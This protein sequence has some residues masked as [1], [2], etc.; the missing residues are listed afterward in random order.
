MTTGDRSSFL[1]GLDYIL[2]FLLNCLRP[3]QVGSSIQLNWLICARWINS[4]RKGTELGIGDGDKD[5]GMG[6]YLLEQNLSG[7]YI[8]RYM[9]GTWWG[10][11][12]GCG[13]MDRVELWIDFISIDERNWNSPRFVV[14]FMPNTVLHGSFFCL[15]SFPFS[16]TLCDHWSVIFRSFVDRWF[17]IAPPPPLPCLSWR[18]IYVGRGVA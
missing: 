9:Y 7:P 4:N 5:K 14:S 8:S 10:I 11:V 6:M 2:N 17:W 18:N 3:P 16:L 12:V 1:I 15:F 13:I